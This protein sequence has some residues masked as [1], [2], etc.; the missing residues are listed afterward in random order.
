VP[1]CNT[2]V[3]PSSIGVENN[4]TST[5]D[6]GLKPAP[7]TIVSKSDFK[8]MLELSYNAEP[9]PVA[10]ADLYLLADLLHGDLDDGP[11]FLSHLPNT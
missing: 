1:S 6:P 7:V 5:V 8:M 10:R 4:Q 3:V 9:V 2:I 11:V